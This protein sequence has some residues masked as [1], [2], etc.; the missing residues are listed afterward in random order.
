MRV[1]GMKEFNYVLTNVLCFFLYF[2]Y[3]MLIIF[4]FGVYFFKFK[5]FVM[6]NSSFLIIV[7]IGW[8]F[9]QISM[10]F[11]FSA[12]FE[13]SMFSLIMG[14][15]GTFYLIAAATINN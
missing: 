14:Y 1:N 5:I 10:A 7:F 12:I 8:G 2:S 3:N 15:A 4:G 13:N 9:V 11:F 6:T